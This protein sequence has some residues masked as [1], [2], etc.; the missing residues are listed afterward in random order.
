MLSVI[1]S[2]IISNAPKLMTLHVSTCQVVQDQE[3]EEFSLEVTLS[4]KFPHR[5]LFRYIV[6]NKRICL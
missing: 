3:G 4:E 1:F 6:L 2:E 5:K